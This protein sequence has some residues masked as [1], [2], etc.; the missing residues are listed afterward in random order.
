MPSGAVRMDFT[1]VIFTGLSFLRIEDCKIE[2]SY[3]FLRPKP[4]PTSLCI[5][6]RGWLEEAAV[7]GDK[8]FLDCLFIEGETQA[9]CFRHRDV[10]ILDDW[11][12]QIVNKITP[13]RY[14]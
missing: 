2:H 13:E 1:L 10:A 14:I 5:P 11:F 4:I 12:W 7:F 8:M 6:L 9:G 3:L